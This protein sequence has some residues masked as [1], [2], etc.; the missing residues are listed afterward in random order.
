MIVTERFFVRE[1]ALVVNMLISLTQ[2]S[3]RFMNLR[4][5]GTYNM[6]VPV[7]SQSTTPI[8]PPVLY[9]YLPPDRISILE[10]MEVRFG[11]P[12]EFNDT[13]DTHYLIP[14]SQGLKGTA[15]RF[16]LKSSLGIFC[17]TERSNNHLMWAHYARNHTGFIL[18]FKATAP[19]FTEGGRVLRK[20]SYQKAPPVIPEADLN[21]CFCKS[22]PWKYEQEWRCVR[23][24]ES[25]ES[26]VVG[27]EPGMIEQIIFG[28]QM[29]AWQIARVLQYARTYEM[30]DTQI[31]VS[32]PSKN[33]FKI[34]NTPVKMAVC[35]KC[36]GNGYSI[37]R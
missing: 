25:T 18:G 13:F 8:I 22:R 6:R 16:R 28:H 2:N 20:V 32:S 15:A 9:K 3:R 23:R 21:V 19:F 31:L 34:M 37:E 4:K 10:D 5:N 30:F 24:F 1:Y 17:M 11:R 29:E 26:R 7:L 27:I 12:S 35:D 33:S 36:D 14:K